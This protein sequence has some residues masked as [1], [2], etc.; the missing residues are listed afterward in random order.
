MRLQRGR[1]L[2]CVPSEEVDHVIATLRRTALVVVVAAG[3]LVATAASA[4]AATDE[5]T[6]LH[7]EGTQTQVSA[8]QYESYGGLLGDF[9]TL[10][11]DPLYESD[12]FVVG[13]GTERFVGCV[14]EDLDGACAES[15]PSGE[16]RFDFIEWMTLDPSTGA[17][18][19]SNCTHPITGGSDGFHGARGIV[20]MHAGLVDGDIEITYE[21]T[22]VLDAVP[23][24]APAAQASAPQAFAAA[25]GTA[26]GRGY[27]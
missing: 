4:T 20:T 23:T 6:M 12:S 16:L 26:A 25:D 24:D 10:T 1:S 14:D 27:C 3:T 13:T 8:D 22:V 15:E 7:V 19:E 17:L 9:W 5:P 21:G 18:I 11:F 2:G